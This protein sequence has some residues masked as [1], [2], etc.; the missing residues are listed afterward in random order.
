VMPE[1]TLGSPKLMGFEHSVVSDDPQLRFRDMRHLAV[2]FAE[3]M[4]NVQLDVSCD[5][6]LTVWSSVWEDIQVLLDKHR[7]VVDGQYYIG[8]RCICQNMY[9]NMVC[10]FN[11]C[12]SS[13]NLW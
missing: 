5:D 1:G 12:N 8:V 10:L 13:V 7:D 9:N 11:S 2:V 6:D 3:L 4:F